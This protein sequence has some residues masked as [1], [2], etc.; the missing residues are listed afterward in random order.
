MESV[1]IPRDTLDHAVDVNIETSRSRPFRDSTV[2]ASQSRPFEV[3][4]RARHML[5][6]ASVRST[7]MH[8]A[9]WKL[10]RSDSTPRVR[11]ARSMRW[12]RIRRCIPRWQAC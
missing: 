7:A 12:N 8:C 4:T 10:L 1:S 5:V 3:N 11:A 9:S 6:R 2:T